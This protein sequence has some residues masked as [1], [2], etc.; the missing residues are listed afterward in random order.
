MHRGRAITQALKL[1]SQQVF[2]DDDD[3]DDILPTSSQDVKQKSLEPT[4]RKPLQTQTQ[5]QPQQQPTED[6]EYLPE[7]DDPR[8]TADMNSRPRPA[9]SQ[10]P[11]TPRRDITEGDYD[12]INEFTYS[13]TPNRRRAQKRTSDLAFYDEKQPEYSTP[14]RRIPSSVPHMNNGHNALAGYTSS[15]EYELEQQLLK[16]QNQFE[17]LV[18]VRYTEPEILCK[19]FRNTAER[20]IEDSN[21]TIQHLQQRLDEKEKKLEETE[22]ALQQK[23]IALLQYED[24]IQEL[25]SEATQQQQRS[26]QMLNAEKEQ[27]NSEK[28]VLQAKV[29]RLE[30]EN[31]VHLLPRPKS[32]EQKQ[33]VETYEDLSGMLITDVKQTNEGYAYNCIQTGSQGTLQFKLYRQDRPTR[34]FRYQPILD[35]VRDKEIISRLPPKMTREINFRQDQAPV[36]HCKLSYALLQSKK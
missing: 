25:K 24:E 35:P 4:F 20:H 34:E 32:F 3:F 19:N 22:S 28:A 13:A 10:V 8:I 5:T 31:N 23:N 17:E 29:T 2:D 14:N 21:A 26:Q 16:L 27:W 30:A 18:N 7:L 6:Y 33:L 15:R 9:Y 36:F 1:R 11:T 12:A